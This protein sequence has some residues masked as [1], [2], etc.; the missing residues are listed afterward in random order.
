MVSRPLWRKLAAASAG[1]WLLLAAG[2]SWGAEPS[3]SDKETARLLMAQGRERRA[4]GDLKGAVESFRGADQIM[5]VPTTTLELARAQIALGHLVEGHDSLQRAIHSPVEDR[6]PA[7]FARA[8]DEAR[9]LDDAVKK[10]IPSVRITSRGLRPNEPFS[11]TI[12]GVAVPGVALSVARVLDPGHHVIEATAGDATGRGEITLAEGESRDVVLELLVPAGQPVSAPS[13]PA[14]APSNPPAARAAVVPPLRPS[15]PESA[16]SAGTVLVW[17]GFSL[18]GAGVL[19]GSIA[20]LIALDKKSSAAQGCSGNLCPP[21]TWGDVDSA[22]SAAS[23]SNVAFAVAGAG[24]ALG[25]IGLLLGTG[26]DDGPRRAGAR[27]RVALD[28]TGL[29]G[30]L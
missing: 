24:A 20:G 10:R 13:A 25:V 6:E 1:V 17:S 15:A 28:A 19:A 18:A 9:A 5:R 21:P 27:P 22:H 3:A 11:V 12:D 2:P 7:A 8:R 23:V 14:P 26:G 16:T 30:E 4:R 29:H